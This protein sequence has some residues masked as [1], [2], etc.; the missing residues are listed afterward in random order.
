VRD[1]RKNEAGLAQNLGRKRKRLFFAW[2]DV[3]SLPA[4]H[5]FG[6]TCPLMGDPTLSPIFSLRKKASSCYQFD[7]INGF[8]KG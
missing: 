5:F 8:I 4:R 7:L 2:R 6:G 1:R 3:F